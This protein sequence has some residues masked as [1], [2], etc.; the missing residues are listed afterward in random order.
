M[1]NSAAVRA[2]S[3]FV[4][5]SLRDKMKE[6][7]RRIQSQLT[8]ISSTFSTFG[9]GLVAAGA[10]ATAAFGSIAGTIGAAALH[11][12]DSGSELA[13]MSAR[14]GVAA[15]SLSALGYAAKLTGAE[16]GDVE[17][18]LRKMQ[19]LLGAAAGGSKEASDKLAQLGLSAGSLLKMSPE[20]QFATISAA[21]AK[22][23]DPTLQASIAMEL[24]GKSA[25]SILPLIN[26]DIKAVTDSAREL[27]LVLS[28]EDVAAAD[29]LGDSIDTLKMTFKAVYNAIGAAV[30][31][32]L[33][34][35][36]DI[37]TNLVATVGQV[38]NANRALFVGLGALSLVGTAAG[39]A[40][41]TLGG[42]LLGVGGIIAGVGALGPAFLAG[43]GMITAAITPLIPV[44]A[45]VAGGLLAVGATYAAIAYVANEAG[46]L[47]PIF[48]G[49]SSV[50]ST[51]YGTFT[52]AFGGIAKAIS[53][54][55]FSKAAQILWVGIK[56]AFFQGAKSAFDAFIWLFNNGLSAAAAFAQALGKTIWNIFKA[57]PEMLMSALSGGVTLAEILAKAISGGMAG[58]LDK[59]IADAQGQLNAL[60]ASDKKP[61][62]KAKPG[63]GGGL[64]DTQAIED[65]AAA[66]KGIA[67]RIKAL[68][69]ETT[70]MKLGADAFDLYKLKLQGATAEQ[71]NQVRSLQNY[72]DQLKAKAKAEEDAKKATE[73]AKKKAEDDK[74]D[75]MERGKKMAEEVRTPFQVMQD[76]IKEINMLQAAG[77]IDS[78][79][80]GLQRDAARNDFNAPMRDA[81]KN[82]RNTIAEINTQA[83]MDVVHRTRATYMGG[84]PGKN[85]LE[86]TAQSQLEEQRK[87]NQLLE[88]GG[89]GLTVNIRRL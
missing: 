37:A 9:A 71:L 34:A 6:G 75:L 36:T 7:A 38:V 55:E 87:T 63:G 19:K 67:D 82:G 23:Q 25:T 12:A 65:A 50:V 61:G 10:T 60:T 31:G 89:A 51:L 47:K 54:G 72:R 78:K 53:A 56:L 43:W 62:D 17:G 20:K 44:I 70:E 13:D 40:L 81:M 33:T 1:S 5:V 68:Q 24:F 57:I 52:Q 41:L 59:S 18:A 84:A 2:G 80:A 27:G 49:L 85:K 58:A 66:R 69:D 28:D 83:S 26:S 45:A 42:A 21:I 8:A 3:A 88:R 48:D 14:T 74:K 46:L 73:D 77:A 64:V 22:I 15:S 39:A 29:A 86:E 79:T 32:P 11:F 4:E 16:L 76:K 35:F 30:S